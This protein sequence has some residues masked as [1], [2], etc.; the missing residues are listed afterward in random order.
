MSLPLILASSLKDLLSNLLM[1][2]LSLSLSNLAN[3]LLELSNDLLPTSAFL[4]PSAPEDLLVKFVSFYKL[5]LLA[6]AHSREASLVLLSSEESL[7][8]Q[9]AYQKP[10]VKFTTLNCKSKF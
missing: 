2:N 9:E 5:R 10:R 3:L 4:L 6:T 1:I 7:L 8:I